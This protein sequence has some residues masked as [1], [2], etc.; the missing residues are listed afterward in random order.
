MTHATFYRL[1]AD[2]ILVVHFA[3]VAFVVLGLLAVWAGRFLGWS[4]VRNFWFRLAH[5]LAIGIVAAE[6]LGGVICPLTTWEARLRELAGATGGYQGS[7]I[8]HWVHRLMFFEAS[9]SVFTATYI[10][11]FILVLG[12]FWWVKPR[13]RARR[14][15]SSTQRRETLIR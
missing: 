11:F 12:S 13:W 15:S 1:L 5:V 2:V 3:F 14:A 8:Q 4:W 6:A 10:A 7:F 9:Q